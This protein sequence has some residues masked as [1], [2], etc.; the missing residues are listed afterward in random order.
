[1]LKRIDGNKDFGRW[2]LGLHDL[3]EKE[4]VKFL[5]ASRLAGI[6]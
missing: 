4:A 2:I 1:M 5:L 6:F 3:R